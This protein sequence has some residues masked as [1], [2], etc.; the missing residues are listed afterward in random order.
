MNLSRSSTPRHPDPVGQGNVE[1]VSA[2]IGGPSVSWYE[3]DSG[4]DSGNRNMDRRAGLDL[5]CFDPPVYER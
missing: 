3:E 1:I 5:D 2:T 4:R